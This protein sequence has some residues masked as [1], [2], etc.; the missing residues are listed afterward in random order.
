[1]SLFN[2]LKNQAAGALG[3]TVKNAVTGSNRSVAVVFTSIPTSLQEFAA[4]PQA[5]MQNPF[6]TAAMVVL[7]FGIYKVD[8]NLS[9]S[10]L[11]HLKGP[12]PLSNQEISFI[13]DRMAQNNKV[14]YIAESY[15]L[16]ATPANN[17]TPTVP[18]TVQVNENPYSYEQSGYA[19]V[20]ITCGGA[21]SPRPVK[22]R[23][24]KDGKWYLWEQFLLSDI[25][26]PEAAD[27]WA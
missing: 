26:P 6:D 3:Q 14:E 27:P 21:D 15:F 16:G 18:Y 4:L 12:Q 25:R 13:A 24:A 2:Q 19:Q 11:N 1:M 17:Y 9:L 23:Q 10:M 8:R 7:A 20:F 22:M 5:A